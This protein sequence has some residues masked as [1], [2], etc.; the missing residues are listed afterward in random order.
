MTG[1][2]PLPA[3]QLYNLAFTVPPFLRVT[4]ALL[5]ANAPV[6]LTL[7]TAPSARPEEQCGWLTK[8][9]FVAFFPHLS[10]ESLAWDDGTSESNLDVGVLAERLENVLS[11]NTHEAQAMKD[12]GS[13]EWDLPSNYSQLTRLRKAPHA[14][15]GR[16]EVQ[17]VV[18]P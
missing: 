8:D 7:A 13:A 10:N 14:G 6:S 17:W 11:G 18:V 4:A 3:L 1:F 2:N 9:N 16:I 15:K 5:K 12:C